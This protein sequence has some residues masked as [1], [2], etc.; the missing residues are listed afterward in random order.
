MLAAD[1]GLL[2]VIENAGLGL[3]IG[4]A[5][6]GLLIFVW[7]ARRGRWRNPLA[8]VET[9]GKA[10]FAAHVFVSLAAY[11]LLQIVFVAVATAGAD[12]EEARVPGSGPWFR[13]QSADS[14]AKL[15]VSVLIGIVL[16][17]HR[18]F[19]T[20]HGLLDPRMVLVGVLGAVIVLPMCEVILRMD[21]FLWR[22]VQPDAVQ[23]THVV[24]EALTRTRWGAT[25]L[26][27]GACVVAP[28][29]EE[30]FFRGLLLQT[31]WRYSGHIW[32]SIILSAIAF[33]GV[34]FSQPQDVPALVAMGLALG[35]VRVRYGSLLAC[36]VL[37]GCF[38]GWTMTV[39]ILAPELINS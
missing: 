6:G 10:P 22:W 14:T 31:V 1:A 21:Q 29:S 26:V 36:V 4:G 27:L 35:Y 8:D 2:K 15:L 25:Q 18:T 34:H 20:R 16:W 32:F 13:V 17:R 23:P 39:A 5:L 19:R 9:T 28:I 3:Q 30:L 11:F 38:N 12:H 33:G 37:H 7:L 24:L